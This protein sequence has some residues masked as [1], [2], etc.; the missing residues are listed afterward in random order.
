MELPLSHI[1][2]Y[3][4]VSA[5]GVLDRDWLKHQLA[6]LVVT[7]RVIPRT[8]TKRGRDASREPTPQFQYLPQCVVSNWTY[9][10]WHKILII[11]EFHCVASTHTSMPSLLDMDINPTTPTISFPFLSFVPVVTIC[12]E[13]KKGT[14]RTLYIVGPHV[15]QVPPFRYNNTQ[16]DPF[17]TPFNSP[18]LM[19]Q[20]LQK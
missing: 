13:I 2:T 1:L 9:H 18:S 5:S 17:F 4:I 10:I 19:Q 14:S 20:G 11:T 15:S 7:R 3:Q 16:L 8:I 12:L 6:G